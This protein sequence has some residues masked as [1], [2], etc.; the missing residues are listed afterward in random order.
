M[1][2]YTGNRLGAGSREVG[3]TSE[4]GQKV[5]IFGYNI[6]NRSWG[7]NVQHGDYS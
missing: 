7:C 5:Q 4:G 1:S 2:S 3:E 6:N